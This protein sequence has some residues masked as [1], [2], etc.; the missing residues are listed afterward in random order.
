MDFFGLNAKDTIMTIAVI[1]GPVLAVQAQKILE[2]GREKKQ[3]RLF[4]FKTLMSTRATRLSV[5]HVQALNLID[6]EFY[7]R[8]IPLLK[9]RHQTKLEQEVTHAWHAYIDHLN[10]IGMKNMHGDQDISKFDG[11]IDELFTDMLYAISKALNYDFDKVQLRRGCYR[12]QGHQSNEV[13]A[14]SIMSNALKVLSGHQ[15]VRMSVDNLHQ[16]DD[17]DNV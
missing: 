3:R 14:Q 7:G 16:Q 6:I 17:V 4:I 9:I 5:E 12:P 13:M 1:L 8:L 10:E 2:I 15:A 11:R